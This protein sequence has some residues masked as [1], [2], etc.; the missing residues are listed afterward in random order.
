MLQNDYDKAEML[1]LKGLPVM[2]HTGETLFVAGI[3][4]GLGNCYMAKGEYGQAKAMID[5]AQQYISRRESWQPPNLEFFPLVSNYYAAKGD[6]KASIAYMDSALQQQKAYQK[7]YNAAQIFQVERKLYDAEKLIR[8]KRL[9]AEN[10]E[11]RLYRNLL[12]TSL[13]VLV[14]VTGFYVMYVRLRERK[15]RVL[16]KRIVEENRIQTELAEARRLLMLQQPDET[17]TPVATVEPENRDDTLLK[18]LDNLMQTEHLFT[19][20]KLDRKTLAD[21]L[22]TNENYLCNAIRDGY[23]LQYSDYI[24]SLR[25]IH[26][27]RLLI[28]SPEL[29]IK[30]IA[31]QSGFHSYKYFHKLFRD[32]Y[33][34]SPSLFRN[35]PNGKN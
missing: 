10:I 5:S 17:G 33:G 18:R 30:E 7:Q 21:R 35:I 12:Y 8:E 25:L 23:N 32:K 3:Y 27:N 31:L 2:A 22:K 28:N 29:S 9:E 20:P 24:H 15:N 1:L 26:A 14:M 11:K 34:I 6:T 19:N 16:Y 13:V 4:I